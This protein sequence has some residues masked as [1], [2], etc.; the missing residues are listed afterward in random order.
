MLLTEMNMHDQEKLQQFRIARLLSF[1]TCGLPHCLIQIDTSNT[2]AIYCPNSWTVDELLD[3][4]EDLCRYAWLIVGAQSLT[5]Y[6][7]QEEIL[8][9]NIH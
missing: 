2:L 1:F 6:F 9:I 5:L 8:R 7:A 3:D 4:F